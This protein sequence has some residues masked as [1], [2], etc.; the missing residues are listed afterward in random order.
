MFPW[1]LHQVVGQQE[2]RFVFGA[3]ILGHFG[4][5]RA[6]FS[7]KWWA[8]WP[9]KKRPLADLR[10]AGCPY[11]VVTCGRKIPLFGTG[12]NIVG[13]SSTKLQQLGMMNPGSLTP[14]NSCQACVHQCRVCGLPA[15]LVVQGQLQIKPETSATNQWQPSLNHE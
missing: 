4:G 3:Q 9:P 7:Q 8:F 12:T 10:A 13:K 11:Q 14:K 15:V 5:A 1:K 2:G 6:F